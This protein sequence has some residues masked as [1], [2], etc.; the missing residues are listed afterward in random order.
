MVTELRGRGKTGL[1]GAYVVVHALDG[2]LD[3]GDGIP[4]NRKSHW[5]DRLRPADELAGLCDPVLGTPA[6]TTHHRGGAIDAAQRV[7]LAE[8]GGRGCVGAGLAVYG[9]RLQPAAGDREE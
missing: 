5:R 8:R 1:P 3:G 6:C 4:P 7:L 2:V 9:E